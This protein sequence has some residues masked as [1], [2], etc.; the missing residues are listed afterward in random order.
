MSIDFDLLMFDFAGDYADDA[1]RAEAV[2]FARLLLYDP[3]LNLRQVESLL[4]VIEAA[5]TSV[6]VSPRR[7]FSALLAA[8]G[9][10]GIEDALE[11]RKATPEL[12]DALL[13]DPVGLQQAHERLA[14]PPLLEPTEL[15][16]RKVE[17]LKMKLDLVPP[18]RVMIRNNLEALGTE[19]LAHASS[20]YLE[21]ESLR[22][23]LLEFA[24]AIRNVRYDNAK[25]TENS[26]L[27]PAQVALAKCTL[28]ELGRQEPVLAKY[29][30]D[31]RRQVAEWFRLVEDAGLPEGY[32]AELDGK[33]LKTVQ[34]ALKRLYGK[35]LAM[36]GS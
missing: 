18:N 12:L 30:P 24:K 23:Y 11:T 6:P 21:G 14:G 15:A 25:V 8:L 13:R 35:T 3:V 9:E 27:V 4:L 29:E 1:K 19:A 2:D 34:D 26:S 5:G 16:R 17:E 32:V 22:E 7:D 20:E 33:N 31:A 10:H 36:Q 28:A